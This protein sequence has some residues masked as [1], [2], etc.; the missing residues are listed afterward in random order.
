MFVSRLLNARKQTKYKSEKLPSNADY[1]AELKLQ[2]KD[3][4]YICK[5]DYKINWKIEI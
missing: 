4:C 2:V 1:F 5:Q 3:T